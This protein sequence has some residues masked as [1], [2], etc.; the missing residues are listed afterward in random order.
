MVS[1]DVTKDTYR[2]AILSNID[3]KGAFKQD[4][5]TDS[6]GDPA[7]QYIKND[8]GN[9]MVA[10]KTPDGS[11]EFWQQTDSI[12]N[13]GTDFRAMAFERRNVDGTAYLDENRQPVTFMTF[14][15]CTGTDKDNITAKKLITGNFMEERYANVENFTGTVI[16]GMQERAELNN[17]DMGRVVVGTHSMGAMALG[18]GAHMKHQYGLENVQTILIEPVGAGQ[19][20]EQLSARSAAKYYGENPT[21]NQ[22]KSIANTLTD[23]VISIRSDDETVFSELNIGDE[24]YDNAM[25]GETYSYKS[26][27]SG[28][29]S[30]EWFRI[31]DHELDSVTKSLMT[32]GDNALTRTQGEDLTGSEILEGGALLSG[33]EKWWAEMK[34][35]LFQ[36]AL[37]FIKAIF[38][39]ESSD[40]HQEQASQ[41][42]QDFYSMG[43]ELGQENP[44]ILADKGSDPELAKTL[45]SAQPSV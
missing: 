12:H 1:Q 2:I 45:A 14:P 27:D 24:K 25:V 42:K 34:T 32:E 6:S 13:I 37:P 10:M 8:D 30:I 21:E 41:P 20:L 22:V 39:T 19:V 43:K 33:F 4:N 5:I 9:Y 36:T 29:E 16:A 31:E 23:N 7:T 11:V 15:G 28:K 3:E 26:P 18:A 38:N 44:T 40:Q 17:H 35:I